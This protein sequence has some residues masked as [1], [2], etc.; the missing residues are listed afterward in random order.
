M[1]RRDPSIHV[2][3][4]ELIELIRGEGIVFPED[5]VD[6]MMKK[7]VGLNIRNR[8]IVTAKRKAKAKMARSLAVEDNI[9]ER[10]N[11]IYNIQIKDH[12]IK[13]GPIY[14]TSK[15]YLTLKEIAYNAQNFCRLFNF[16]KLEEGF[17]QYI[18]LGISLLKN[19]YSIYRL[20][21]Y[22]S[23]I[24]L[25][26]ENFL[27]LSND[28][29]PER[30]QKM[31]EA[32]RRACYEH[33]NSVFDTDDPNKTI[34]FYYAKIEADEIKAD[35]DDWMLAQFNKWSYLDSVPEYVQLYGDDAKLTYNK[36][37]TTHAKDKVDH[38][39]IKRVKDGDIPLKQQKG[40]N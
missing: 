26:Y 33:Y 39:Y 24:I 8:I 37:I 29:T 10:F 1:S 32:W 20:K 7:A 36:Y 14:K 27:L 3:R 6:S 17:G 28:P 16:K 22:D 38:E 2:R 12:N 21:G 5:C 11:K 34:A 23:K 9:V 40:R 30:T 19:K 4:S 13:T 25:T 15:S 31:H 18:K 35:Y